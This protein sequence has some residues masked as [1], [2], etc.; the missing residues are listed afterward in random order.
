[1]VTI[2]MTYTGIMAQTFT[3]NSIIFFF[4]VFIKHFFFT[5]TFIY[6]HIYIRFLDKY[7]H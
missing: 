7:L 1:M 4:D 2:S 6:I 5:S 3:S